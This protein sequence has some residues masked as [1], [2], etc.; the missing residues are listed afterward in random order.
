M[1]HHFNCS[2]KHW[3]PSR[4]FAYQKQ[5]ANQRQIVHQKLNT[6]SVPQARRAFEEAEA[7]S[8]GKLFARLLAANQWKS[9]CACAAKACVRNIRMFQQAMFQW[10]NGCTLCL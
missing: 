10:L 7:M 4:Q 3:K 6:R 2:M 9:N 1:L 5:T 8:N